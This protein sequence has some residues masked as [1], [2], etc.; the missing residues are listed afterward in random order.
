LQKSP[1]NHSEPMNMMIKTTGMTA[2]TRAMN[3]PMPVTTGVYPSV[4]EDRRGGTMRGL[5]PATSPHDRGPFLCIDLG[6]GLLV[7]GPP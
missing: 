3:G 1:M 6:L 5:P 2:A 7:D 4:D